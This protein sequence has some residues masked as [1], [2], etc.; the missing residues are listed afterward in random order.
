M[1]N[2][3]E[4]YNKNKMMYSYMGCYNKI[5]HNTRSYN[6]I[7]D[8][9]QILLRKS[10]YENLTY[11]IVIGIIILIIGLIILV[12]LIKYMIDT[13][14]AETM[15][16]QELKRILFDYKSYIQ[17]TNNDVNPNNYKTIQIN[18]F[19]EILRMRDILQA[20]ILM[21]TEEGKERTKFMIVKDG[22]LYIYV[23]G[24]KEI[25]NELRAKSAEEK[26]KKDDK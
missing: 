17:T 22:M 4:Y 14:S 5:I 9:G 1:N 20:P 25:R 2:G 26:K 10:E 7:E 11:L 13:R 8:E 12:K 24:A 23:L 19:N 15:Y 18:T 6:V 16:D 3:K 21:Y